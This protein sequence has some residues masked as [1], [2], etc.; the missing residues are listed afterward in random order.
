MNVLAVAERAFQRVDSGDVGQQTQFDLGVVQGHQNP[1]G[2]GH[3]RVSD[4]S[5]VFGPDGNVL[6]VGVCRRQAAGGRGGHGKGRVHA[7]RSRVDL[8][9]QGVGIRALELVELSPFQHRGRQLVTFGGQRFQHVGAGGI[10]AGFPFVPAIQAQFVE[11]DLTQ[12]FRGAHVEFTTGEPVHVLLQCALAVR[13]LLAEPFQFL[14][15]HLDAFG[16]HVGQHRH[17]GPFQGFVGRHHAFGQ[18]A[19][20]EKPVK[21]QGHV[22]VFRGIGQGPVQGNQVKRHL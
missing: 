21:P 2:F 22:R 1:S 6:Q 14:P 19:R 18:Q 20:F 16:F 8:L 12:L 15:V 5:A 10:G 13:E 4:L 17:E 7:T 3:E 11:Q 9:D